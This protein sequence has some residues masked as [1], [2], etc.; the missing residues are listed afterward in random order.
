MNSVAFSA[1]NHELAAAGVRGIWLWHLVPGAPPGDGVELRGAGDVQAVAF[2]PADGSLWSGTNQVRRWDVVGR[3]ATSEVIWPRRGPGHAVFTIAFS[4]DGK[5]VAFAGRGGAITLVDLATQVSHD[6]PSGGV[7][8]LAFSPNGDILASG[9]E[10]RTI[11]LW[12]THTDSVIRQLTGDSDAIFGL[13]FSDDGRILASGSADD[14]VRL[15]DVTTG[16]A[17]GLPL[18][19][20]HGYVRSVAFDPVGGRLASG[21]ADGTVRFWDPSSGAQIG[22]PLTAGTGGVR[23][24]AFGPDGRSFV[25]AGEGG[26]VTW[27]KIFTLPSSYAQLRSY[28]C[29]LVGTGLSP[30]EWNESVPGV[31]YENP[32]PGGAGK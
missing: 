27:W 3:S 9:G 24:V 30:T 6:L 26:A 21:S 11:R 4:A 29:G 5:E 16:Q 20:H 23:T 8:S 14:T 12:N 1:R 17:Q 15:W 7:Y 13:A 25:S 31:L 2:D 10:D 28:V 18:L 32:C 22:A 19:G